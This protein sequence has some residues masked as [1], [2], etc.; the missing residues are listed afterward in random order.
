MRILFLKTTQNFV[1]RSM[2]E[3]LPRIEEQW[4][5]LCGPDYIDV[6][7]VDTIRPSACLDKIFK[8]EKIVVS[9][10]N[11][12]IA[13]FLHIIRLKMGIQTPCIFYL[14]GLATIGLWPA[15]EFGLDDFF[16]DNDTFLG[17]CE[18]DLNS[19]KLVFENARAQKILFPTYKNELL[20]KRGTDSPCF[21]YVGRLSRQKNLHSLLVA[22]AAF[23]KEWPVQIELH[24]FGMGDELD[25]PNMEIK[26]S[27]YETL[28]KD[29][30]EKLN[31]TQ[32][33]HFHGWVKREEITA[34]YQCHNAVF[35][36]PSLHSD[37]NFGMAALQAIEA[38]HPCLLSQ[39]GGHKNYIEAFKSGVVGIP[40]YNT[41]HGPFT[42]ITDIKEGMKEILSQPMTGPSVKNFSI[43]YQE[44]LLREILNE[45]KPSQGKV[46]IK[47]KLVEDLLAARQKHQNENSQIKQ[48]IFEDYKDPRAHL[49]FH[50]YG[51]LNEN[52]PNETLA[53]PWGK[54]TKDEYILD[55]PHKGE[56]KILNKDKSFF[57]KPE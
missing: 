12:S 47:S 31:L 57:L 49:F 22:F 55:D 52:P 43:D 41:I 51:A 44:V 48:K 16:T 42:R 38:G 25:S 5:R 7:D 53:L 45:K 6:I 32:Q 27:G 15:F 19:L 20:I 37:E 33:I 21:V 14:H 13:Q 28:L 46:L 9:A 4:L 54:L 39:W 24:L 40:V 8:A 34:F 1:W 30:T 18:G 50:A 29:F 17:T 26:R 11:Q 23:Q 3:I 56:I 2:E 10:F 35:V 36:S